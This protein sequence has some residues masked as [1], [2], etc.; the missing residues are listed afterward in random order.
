MTC[1]DF[2]NLS[3]RSGD[4]LSPPGVASN[5]SPPPHATR[6]HLTSHP[7]AQRLPFVP[8]REATRESIR[9]VVG[10]LHS[11]HGVYDGRAV[12]TL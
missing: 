12:C 1:I 11:V 4:P 10:L 6:A 9:K 2:I 7:D 3:R 5:E 8:D